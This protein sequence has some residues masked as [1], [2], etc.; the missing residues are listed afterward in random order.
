[1][2]ASSLVLFIHKPWSVIEPHNAFAA[3][4]QSS[5]IY[6]CGIMLFEMLTGHV[7]F[8][9]SDYDIQ[10]GHVNEPVAFERLPVGVPDW[11]QKALTT[12]LAKDPEDRF[13]DH[14]AFIAALTPVAMFRGGPSVVAPSTAVQHLQN[15][16]PLFGSDNF[17][18][19]EEQ[20]LAKHRI[21]GLIELYLDCLENVTSVSDKVNLHERL[22]AVFETKGQPR[23]ALTVLLEALNI[24]GNYLYFRDELDR[25]A[26]SS[27][28]T[29]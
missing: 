17:N 1:L 20:L 13:H 28:S 29:N 3:V 27:I 11:I 21:D 9:G 24:T 26:R 16:A 2:S 12:A 25:L 4:T 19:R 7:P 6:A 14:R 8:T 10:H 15:R 22:A 5:D 18:R 23:H